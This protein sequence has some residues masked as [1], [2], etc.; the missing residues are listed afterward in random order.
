[1]EE[2]NALK[3]LFKDL[4]GENI[5]FNMTYI[6][7][8]GKKEEFK[9][10]T[11]P[12]CQCD[13]DK[14]AMKYEDL[15]TTIDLKNKYIEQLVSRLDQFNKDKVEQQRRIKNSKLEYIELCKH[16]ANSVLDIVASFDVLVHQLGFQNEE[17]YVKYNERL[18][19]VDC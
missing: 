5:E 2:L 3:E 4:V 1:M 6:D 9:M 11:N 13:K 15:Q 14:H 12:K 8:N 19:S 18:G 16:F 7:K 17:F 10:N